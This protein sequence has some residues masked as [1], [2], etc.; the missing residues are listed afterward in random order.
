M[1]TIFGVGLA[2]R[3]APNVGPC[4]TTPGACSF[5]ITGTDITRTIMEKTQ[6]GI[7]FAM[8]FQSQTNDVDN[9]DYA[10]NGRLLM[11]M[12]MMIIII[13]M[14]LIYSDCDYDCD[15]Y[16]Y[17]SDGDDNIQYI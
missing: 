9:V 11:M 16:D 12:M 1:E 6:N 14:V 7:H 4:Q 5:S 13:I 2:P 8:L 17:D 3:Q 15:D 10:K